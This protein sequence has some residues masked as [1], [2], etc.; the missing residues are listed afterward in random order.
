MNRWIDIDELRRDIA[1][2][3]KGMAM[4]AGLEGVSVRVTIAEPNKRGRR[5]VDVSVALVKR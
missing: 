1:A 3:A 2:Q 5:L 4:A